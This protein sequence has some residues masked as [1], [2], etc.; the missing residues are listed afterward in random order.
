MSPP[1]FA[2]DPA[3]G[4]ARG[5]RVDLGRA[6]RPIGS[7]HGASLS[8]NARCGAAVK[9]DGYGVGADRSG[10]TRLAR[11]GCRDFFVADAQ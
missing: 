1:P 3:A 5:W 7:Q 11:E 8:G 10:A 2:G 4:T 9:A 6:R